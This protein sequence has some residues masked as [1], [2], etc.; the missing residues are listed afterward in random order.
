MGSMTVG[1][2]F[3]AQSIQ[4]F[5]SHDHINLKKERQNLVLP[6]NQLVCLN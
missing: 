6:L 3:A 4:A 2:E 5:H 1:E